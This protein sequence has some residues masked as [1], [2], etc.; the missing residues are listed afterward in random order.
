VQ[1]PAFSKR[2]SSL[3]TQPV[4]STSDHA[5]PDQDA[6]LLELV[7]AKTAEAVAKQ[8]LEELK[9]RFEA[10]RKMLNFT[11]PVPLMP[12]ESPLSKVSSRS[13]ESTGQ[14]PKSSTPVPVATAK[15]PDN[16]SPASGQAA[17]AGSWG[18]GGFFG[19]GKRSLSS[20]NVP[21]IAKK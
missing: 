17:A 6:L 7:N 20:A 18:G 19:W 5:P 16:A 9:G 11:P 10:M 4:L 1:Q 2:T 13:S 14:T 8:E 3:V 15:S 21:T 12:T